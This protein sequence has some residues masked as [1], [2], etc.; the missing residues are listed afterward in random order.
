MCHENCEPMSKWNIFSKELH[1]ILQ[2][3]LDK[4]RIVTVLNLI[5]PW[6]PTFSSINI[7]KLMNKAIKCCW[8]IVVRMKTDTNKGS[9]KQKKIYFHLCYCFF[10]HWKS[11]FFF[12]DRL[13]YWFSLNTMQ[14][15]HKML[16]SQINEWH[17]FINYYTN[18]GS[19]IKLM[20][21]VE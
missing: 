17:N 18:D 2:I 16:R 7:S 5:R 10:E 11:G 1:Q 15:S 14:P 9:W 19:K 3:S 8:F 4:S 12:N 6:N 13:K 21:F 20:N